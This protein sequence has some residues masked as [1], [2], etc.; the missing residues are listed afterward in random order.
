[1]DLFTLDNLF[2]LSTGLVAVYMAIRLVQEMKKSDVKL[3]HNIF[4]FISFAVLFVAG[5]LIIFFGF[6]VLAEPSIAIVSTLIPFGLAIGLVTEFYKK[7]STFYLILML[8]GLLMIAVTR[9]VEVSRFMQIFPYAFF[10]SIGGLT[11][12]F[13]PIFVVKAKQAASGF[14]WVTIGGTL[15]GLGGVALA[16]LKS[17]S[18]LLFFSPEF[19]MAILAPLLLLMVLAFTMGLMKKMAA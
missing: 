1:M 12:F 13:V 14:I 8:L 5:V 19:V 17:G 18:Q 10:H 9:Y 16:F 2:L 7:A 6:E 15:I 4:Y 3:P 11:I